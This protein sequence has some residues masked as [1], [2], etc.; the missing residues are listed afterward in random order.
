[1]RHHHASVVVA[2][3][4]AVLCV[5]VYMRARASHFQPFDHFNDLH[6]TWLLSYAIEGN[7]TYTQL[8]T[9]AD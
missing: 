6:E 8:I 4:A 7:I 9:N 3:A 5:C 2:A 1:M